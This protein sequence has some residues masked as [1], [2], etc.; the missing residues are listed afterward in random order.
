MEMKEGFLYYLWENRLLTGALATADDVPIEVV[1]TGF[2]N[3]DSGPDFL[4]AKVKIDTTLWAGNVEMHVRT[5]DWF[6]HQH[7]LDKAY[8]NVVLHV[9]YENDMDDSTIPVLELKGRFDESLYSAYQRFVTAKGWIPCEKTISKVQQFTWLSWLDRMVAERLQDKAVTVAKLLDSNTSDWEETFYR[10]MLH[11]FGLKVNNEAFEYL[12]CILPHKTLQKHASDITQI[13]AMLFGCAGFLDQ[14]FED[15]YPLLL[16]REY[17]VMKAKFG[18]LSM[19]ADR[20]KFMRM[21]P[22]NFPTLRLAQI[23]QIVQR[24]GNLFS[25]IREAKD[26]DEVK[27]L[28][29]V[30]TSPYWETHYRFDCLSDKKVKHL[31]DAASDVLMINAVVPLLFCYGKVYDD[32]DI[33]EKAIGY[34]EHLD[35]E[36]NTVTR[37]F[38]AC[39]MP[40]GNAMQS[41][42]M[43]NLYNS[44]CRPRRCL[45]CR[46][47]NVLLKQ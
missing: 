38:A 19:P 36:N 4:E 42:A 13:E 27:A 20:W 1:S 28:F 33:C 39:K 2:R 31:G 5:S 8:D 7:H 14:D 25:K 29:D 17:A 15:E 9:V 46:I 21:R 34:L 43:L 23:A 3:K 47:G 32:Q 44:Y 41:Q 24:N 16:K 6:R 37:H 40:S 26:I 22:S 30:Q 12:A 35:S 10:L 45:E 18:L 11:Y